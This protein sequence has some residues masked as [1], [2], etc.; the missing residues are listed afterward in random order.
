MSVYPTT[1]SAGAALILAHGAGAGQRSAFMIGAAHALAQRGVLT[2]T[3]DFPYIAQRRKVPDKGPVLE[4]AWR[5]AV[6][7]ASARPEFRSLPLF[8]GGKSMGGRIASQAA[9]AGLPQVSGLVYLGYPLHPPG[10]PDQRRDRHLPAITVPMLFVQGSNDAFG[11]ADE[12]RELIPRLN[13]STVLHEITGGD[14]SFKVSARAG[15]T[16]A[17]VLEEV[18]DVVARFILEPV[19]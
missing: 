9:A 12:I 4:D 10:K 19:G 6:T 8:I 16:Q 13:R 14:H 5:A 15:R 7:E 2:A 18:F 1:E 17:S 11:T 3:F